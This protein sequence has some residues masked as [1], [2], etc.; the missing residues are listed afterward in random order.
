MQIITAIELTQ[1]ADTALKL[2]Q[3][4]TLQGQSLGCSFDLFDAKQGD[5]L[6]VNGGPFGAMTRYVCQDIYLGGK[7]CWSYETST[8]HLDQAEYNRVAF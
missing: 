2:G 8:A 1:A 6:F 7:R 4:V 5:V 3:A